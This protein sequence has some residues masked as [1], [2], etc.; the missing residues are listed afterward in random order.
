[1]KLK[2]YL[3]ELFFTNKRLQFKF[4]ILTGLFFLFPVLGFIVFGGKYGLLYD[5]YFP[6]ILG[7]ILAFVC[8]GFLLFRGLFNALLD[9]S[10][11]VSH[12][13]IQNLSSGRLQTGSVELPLEA[14]PLTRQ[15]HQPSGLLEKKSY[16]LA[17]LK[18]FSEI[19]HVTF[20]PEEILYI[21]LERSLALTDSDLGSILILQEPDRKAFVVAACI[22]G[23]EFV[24][25][26]DRIDFETSI[27]KYAVINK[28]PLL[29]AD[30]E[31]DT[32]FDRK[33][34]TRYGT[35]SFICMPI[36]TGNNI[37]GVLTISRKNDDK[38]FT[39][40]D[41]E[42]L[43]P[44]ISNAVFTYDNLHYL[45]KIDRKTRNLEAIEKVLKILS[46]S[47]K[48]SELLQTILAEIQEFVPFD[49][50]VV[51]AIDEHRP[52]YISITGLL[53]RKP[54]KIAN[55]NH[56]HI[57]GSNL[58]KALKQDS[59]FVVNH[60]MVSSNEVEKEL[61]MNQ[62]CK[63]CLLVPL[64]T[65]GTTKGLLALGAQ[66]PDILNHTDDLIKW[67]PRILALAIERNSLS[68][69]VLQ[70]NQELNTIR[71]IGG[72]LASS[73]FDIKQ[74]L[75]YT[76]DMIRVLMN[77]EAGSLYLVQGNELEF[78]A[79]FNIEA[80]SQNKLRLKL[81][82]GIPGL[83]AARG[84]SIIVNDAQ[85]SGHFFPNAEYLT[86]FKPRSA[87]CVPIIS[88]GK[89]ISVIEVL[90]KTNGDFVANDEELLQSIGSS[91][92]IAIENAS[93]YRET[94]SMAEQERAI[95][96]M[97]QKYVPEEVLD[98]I[99]CSSKT[100]KD[101]VEE[102]RTLTLINI[103]IRNF[104]GM[105]RRLGP[106]KTVFLLNRFFSTMGGIVFKH[107]GIVDKYLGD[108]FL[109]IFGAPVS[110]T[111]DADNALVAALEMQE[112]VSTLN[113]YLIK[114]FGASVS[115]GIS[116]HTGEVVVGSIGFDMKMDYT[117]IGDSVNDV[118]RLQEL[119]KPI[120]NGILISENTSR[121]ARSHLDVIEIEPAVYQDTSLKNTKIY[122]L[123]GF[124]NDYEPILPGRLN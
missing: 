12:K 41:I 108:G 115:I 50:A 97:F 68:A 36:K 16:A 67:V 15:C 9:I 86:D 82:Q 28:S 21:A 46:S 78:A 81:G 27:A 54:A 92:S 87:L 32:R 42:A 24:K 22:G 110:S 91:V 61:F 104:S 93:L 79:A 95:R 25:K 69:A 52:D 94:I 3:E 49:L 63:S 105:A 51:M 71:Q 113:D 33:N 56:Y 100:G 57:Q 59:I 96:S 60:T 107:H 4:N 89:V 44:L 7:S 35:K 18:E 111:R 121:A 5:D 73:T 14:E 39:Q 48:G 55:G 124:K 17:V 76:L 13:A 20:D 116:V 123:L 53:A 103:D 43:T 114:E 102:L 2:K 117:V 112:A 120:T 72:A 88:Q 84:K 98:Q 75:N 80:V 119:T 85:A 122:E 31:K 83:V 109:A 74:V 40:Q 58:Y 10:E 8:F 6:L 101:L 30:I 34:R 26:G 118:F 65:N 66:Y 1:M 99:I 11:N 23:G 64:K 90:N 77:V 29:V 38:P 62:G 45:K 19:C 106:Q 70:R 37:A 47:Y